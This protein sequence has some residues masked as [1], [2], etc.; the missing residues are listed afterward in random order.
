MSNDFHELAKALSAVDDRR[1]T[2]H[3]DRLAQFNFPP[4]PQ[5]YYQPQPIPAPLPPQ[6]TVKHFTYRGYSR[7]MEFSYEVDN[8]GGGREYHHVF[9]FDFSYDTCNIDFI[10]NDGLFL[11]LQQPAERFVAAFFMINQKDVISAIT[12]TNKPKFLRHDGKNFVH[13]V[14]SSVGGGYYVNGCNRTTFTI[15]VVLAER[16]GTNFFM[17]LKGMNYDRIPHELTLGEPLYYNAFWHGAPRADNVCIR[18]GR[19]FASTL[20]Q[21]APQQ[22][23]PKNIE[24]DSAQKKQKTAVVEEYDPTNPYPG[25]TYDPPTLTAAQESERLQHILNQPFT[26]LFQNMSKMSK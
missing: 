20:S 25:V 22:R 12:K 9:D 5:Q 21:W 24:K 11:A 6:T 23:G 19:M 2:I 10:P 7:H 15:R 1:T 3:P 18:N 26:S 13:L 8:E 17:L 14:F 16:P 4:S